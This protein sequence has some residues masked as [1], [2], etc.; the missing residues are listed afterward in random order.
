MKKILFI[1]LLLIGSIGNAQE[2][3]VET[4]SFQDVL[5]PYLERTL[6]GIEKGVEYAS[7][8]IPVVLEQYVLYEAITNWITVLSG[9]ILIIGSWKFA[10]WWSRTDDFDWEKGEYAIPIVVQGIIFNIWGIVNIICYFYDAIL[11]TFFPK[12][13]LVKEFLNYM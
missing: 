6:E 1:A 2:L 13:F 5:K 8:E 7:E 10:I 11:T 4:Q 9:F 12:L 3:Q